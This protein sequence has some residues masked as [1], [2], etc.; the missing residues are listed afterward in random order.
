MTGLSGSG[1][2]YMYLI[3]EAMADD[4]VVRRLPELQ[5]AIEEEVEYMSGAVEQE[6]YS[7]IE[8]DVLTLSA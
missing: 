5:L 2:A 8:F 6:N 1:P 4:G 3:L 7:G